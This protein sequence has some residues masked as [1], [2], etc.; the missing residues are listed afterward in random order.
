MAGNTWTQETGDRS[1]GRVGL[2]W[3][4]LAGSVEDPGV[5]RRESFAQVVMERMLSAGAGP[6]WTRG[7]W[8]RCCSR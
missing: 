7:A 3:T 1:A 5:T 2:G 6:G 8:I 4:H